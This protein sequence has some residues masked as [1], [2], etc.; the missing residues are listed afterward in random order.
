MVTVVEAVVEAIVAQ[1]PMWQPVRI[2]C[3]SLRRESRSN[4]GNNGRKAKLLRAPPVLRMI[5]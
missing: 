4:N 5:L 1:G 2:L 3:L